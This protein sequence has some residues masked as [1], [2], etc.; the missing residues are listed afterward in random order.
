MGREHKPADCDRIITINNISIRAQRVLLR[1]KP[2][3]TPSGQSTVPPRA[4]RVF[5]RDLAATIAA[6]GNEITDGDLTI[7]ITWIEEGPMKDNRLPMFYE[8]RCE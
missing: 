1:P 6:I 7:A 5:P 4:Y 2:D 3:A 8:L